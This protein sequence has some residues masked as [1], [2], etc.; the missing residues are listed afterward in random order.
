MAELAV[1][2]SMI[3]VTST[4]VTILGV[5]KR[6][7]G[8]SQAITELVRKCTKLVKK[9]RKLLKMLEGDTQVPRVTRR[10]YGALSIRREEFDA[11]LKDLVIMQ[12]RTKCA[13]PVERTEK[14]IMAQGWAKK[15]EVI[16]D[17]LVDLRNGIENIVS[18]WDI[19][20]YVA[21]KVEEVVTVDF[22]KREELRWRQQHARSELIQSGTVNHVDRFQMKFVKLTDANKDALN[23]YGNLD[24]LSLPNALNEASVHVYFT[25]K[26]CC[27]QLMQHSADLLYPQANYWLGIE[28]K[29]GD[30]MEKDLDLAVTHFRAASSRGHIHSIFQL[31]AHYD[32][33]NDTQNVSKYVKMASD[34]HLQRGDWSQSDSSPT[35]DNHKN[36]ELEQ[37]LIAMSHCHSA[38][39]R[40]LSHFFG[41][42]PPKNSKKAVDALHLFDFKSYSVQ[43]D[44]CNSNCLYIRPHHYRWEYRA[45][46]MRD[47]L[48]FLFESNQF[49]S[50]LTLSY[51]SDIYSSRQWKRYVLHA[52]NNQCIDAHIFLAEYFSSF[53]HRNER[54]IQR[55][56]RIAADAGHSQAQRLC[57][58][59]FGRK[60]NISKGVKL[61][62]ERCNGKLRKERHRKD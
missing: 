16:Y 31:I 52:A 38:V 13:S 25:D 23:R 39:L 14:F 1:V 47:Y 62:D 29:Y 6:R 22:T 40:S 56:L 5:I 54:E 10:I 11:V 43:V 7:C 55:H 17:D 50:F 27:I 37:H 26:T 51:N 2:M 19:A 45:N 3:A 36:N 18:N 58:Q 24:N 53:D 44:A 20:Q 42:G 21:T 61:V 12:R 30:R 28:H 8:A 57:R 34:L 9:I 46:V 41:V 48:D 15:L 4:S 33:D 32:N 35:G 59:L 60:T 49:L